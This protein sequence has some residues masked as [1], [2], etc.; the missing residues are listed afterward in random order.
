MSDQVTHPHAHG[1]WRRSL[2]RSHLWN[3]YLRARNKPTTWERI[4][5]QAG[6]PPVVE[7]AIQRILRR[8][9]AL[10]SEKIAFASELLAH[11]RDGL[12][13]G[14]DADDV[15][16][17][18]GDP[19]RVSPLVSRALRRK[20]P[21]FARAFYTV[22]LAVRRI[23]YT[24][25]LVYA[26]LALVFFTRTPAITTD[27]LAELQAPIEAIP[28]HERA[29]PELV[30]LHAELN[31]LRETVAREMGFESAQAAQSFV[32]GSPE[33]WFTQ[34]PTLAPDDPKPD[35]VLA[36]L[37]RAQPIV[38]A[39]HAAAARPAFGADLRLSEDDAGAAEDM[40]FNVLL[41]HL[42]KTRS[43]VRLLMLDAAVAAEAGDADGATDSLE[44]AA[45]LAALVQQ[46]PFLISRLVGY[47][48]LNLAS[49]QAMVLLR[50]HP[51]LLAPDHLDRLARVL[52][53]TI[54]IDAE[55]ERRYHHDAVQRCYAPGHD[56]RL[57]PEGVGALTA[58]DAIGNQ[59][60]G[61]ALAIASHL[62]AGPVTSWYFVDRATV[63]AR[64][65]DVIEGYETAARAPFV[66][67]ETWRAF[68]RPAESLIESEARDPLNATFLPALGKTIDAI[69]ATRTRRDAALLALALHRYR[70]DHGH[71]PDATCDL[72]PSYLP[73]LPIDRFDGHPMRTLLTEAG[74]VIYTL[75]PD[76]DDDHARR[77]DTSPKYTRP[78]NSFRPVNGIP[79]D[80]DWVLFPPEG[81]PW[82][83]LRDAGSNRDPE[84][85]KDAT[86]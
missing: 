72:V 25:A 21:F 29:A 6:L 59:G 5:A 27:H 11:C 74:P 76:R 19:R 69:H 84:L 44:A 41:P 58:I 4:A 42:G 15:A 18:L 34:F 80:G 22:S 86:P 12:D 78:M 3:L 17:S 85:R 7:G 82:A 56:G 83:P 43:V 81:D 38:A 49:D 63:E 33:R 65:R 13:A 24:V 77:P 10:P 32:P 64:F 68:I 50:D 66:A 39:A 55:G 61:G 57:T 73:E 79:P 30:R 60:E 45:R 37:E 31:A 35:R 1:L 9:H 23:I 46:E 54:A 28:A 75:G 52:D 62:I 20:R 51:D 47:A 40:L 8:V 2:D 53:I 16:R 14:R 48:T 67:P 36:L 70:L 71:F 26:L